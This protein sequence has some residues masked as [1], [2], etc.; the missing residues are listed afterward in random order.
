VRK[1]LPTRKAERRWNKD[2]LDR[3]RH[4]SLYAT[5]LETLENDLQAA[6]TQAEMQRVGA[7]SLYILQEL[8]K[9]KVLSGIET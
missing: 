4:N 9:R 6:A 5:I 8:V 2:L 7:G 1:T 3:F